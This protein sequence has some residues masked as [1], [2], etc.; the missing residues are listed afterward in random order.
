MMAKGRQI[1]AEIVLDPNNTLEARHKE[2]TLLEK[3]V[4]SKEKFCYSLFEG[5][6]CRLECVSRHN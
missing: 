1:R 4:P 6:A 2:C 3:H 5:K